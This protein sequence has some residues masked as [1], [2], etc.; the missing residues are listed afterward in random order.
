MTD[1]KLEALFSELN[2]DEIKAF[3]ETGVDMNCEIDYMTKRRIADKVTSKMKGVCNMDNK[4]K[5][6]RKFKIM[7]I[8][9]VIVLLATVSAG[10]AVYLFSLPDGLADTL[11]MNSDYNLKVVVDME[12]CD[13][14]SIQTVQKTVSA[15]G[16]SVT[17]EAIV[18]GTAIRSSFIEA[19]DGMTYSADKAYAIFSIRRDDGKAMLYADHDEAMNA[20][21]IG[22]VVLLPGYMPSRAMFDYDMGLYEENNILYI[23]CDITQ[24]YMFADYD[25]SIAVIGDHVASGDIIR[26]DENGGFY[27]MDSYD[28]IQA[29]FDF[30]IDDS[31]ADPEKAQQH[32]Q[33]D[34]Q[35]ITTPYYFLD[36]YTE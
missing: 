24:V 29:M 15:K 21:D 16:Y 26:M 9:A 27:F 35:F 14:D 6:G 7:L 22:Y 23:A 3:E 18:E 34:Y 32:M 10:A 2:E 28:G 17:F 11:D 30:D 1:K 4:T 12:N 8:A 19:Q 25:L 31:Y 13:E 36:D 20:S 5:K 33:G